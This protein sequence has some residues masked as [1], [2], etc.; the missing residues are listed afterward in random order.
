M[1]TTHRPAVTP[2]DRKPERTVVTETRPP[3]PPFDIDSAITKV[4]A[5]DDAWNT[6]DPTA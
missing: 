2:T 1:T 3:F 6:R 5:A 4:Q